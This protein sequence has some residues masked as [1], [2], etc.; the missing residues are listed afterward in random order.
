[1]ENLI[2]LSELTYLIEI[3]SI[4][5]QVWVD[6]FWQFATNAASENEAEIDQKLHAQ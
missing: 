4:Q 3:P 6:F 1:L 5:T 2:K